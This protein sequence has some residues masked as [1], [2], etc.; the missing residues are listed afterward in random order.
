MTKLRCAW[1]TGEQM[2]SIKTVSTLFIAG[3]ASI[4]TACGVGV[5]S[6]AEGDAPAVSAPLPVQVTVPRS[7][8]IFAKY[9]TTATITSDADAP[10]PARVAGEVVEILVEEGDWPRLWMI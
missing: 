3:V 9:H 6:P 7:A 4:L 10:I 2:N 8:E 1:S 5:A